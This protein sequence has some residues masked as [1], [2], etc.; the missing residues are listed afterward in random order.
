MAEKKKTE[1]RLIYE[2][3]ESQY[4]KAVALMQ[5]D[6]LIVKN[7][8]KKDNYIKAAEMFESVEDFNDAAE[9]A[10]KCRSLAEQADRDSL[11][12]DYAFAVYEYE[13]AQTREDYELVV[14][15]LENTP[16]YKDTDRLRREAE[17]KLD[18]YRFRSG[19]VKAII[20]IILAAIIAVILYLAHS[21]VLGKLKNN[22]LGSSADSANAE[23]TIPAWG[24]DAFREAEPGDEVS[25]GSYQWGVLENDET[26]MLLVLYHAEKEADLRGRPYNEQFTD[27]TWEDSTLRE[28]LN[29]EFFSQA[30]SDE[31]ADS[32]LTETC[33]NSDNP[34]FGTPGGQNTTDRVFVPSGKDIE[35]YQDVFTTI[36]MNIWLRDPGHAENTAMFMASNTRVMEYGYAV[37]STDMYC[38]PMIRISLE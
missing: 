11:E 23:K 12:K 34:T 16:G 27:I 7:S 37:D 20:G 15:L 1:P 17:K 21:G 10:K 13:Q 22:L 6:E 5:E 30:F 8:Y 18:E 3:P 26:T 14:R 38:V 32:I 19:I 4:K 35:K 36:R 31:E 33:E 2:T 28:W 9:L 29:G 25:F 24:E